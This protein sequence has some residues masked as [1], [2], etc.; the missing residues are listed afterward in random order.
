MCSSSCVSCL[1]VTPLALFAF[2]ASIKVLVLLSDASPRASRTH[3]LPVATLLEE[4]SPRG[5]RG[6]LLCLLEIVGPEQIQAPVP[7][8]NLERHVAL[9]PV[10][11]LYRTD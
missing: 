3:P 6:W 5:L 4:V 8:A 7:E 2:R 11:L 1:R 10:A 9:T